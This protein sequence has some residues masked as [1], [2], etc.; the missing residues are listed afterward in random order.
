MGADTTPDGPRAPP[1]VRPRSRMG[2]IASAV[3]V[4][5]RGARERVP[6]GLSC[7]WPSTRQVMPRRARRHRCVAGSAVRLAGW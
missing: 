6:A 5:R 1:R 2:A 4:S 7:R 3:A